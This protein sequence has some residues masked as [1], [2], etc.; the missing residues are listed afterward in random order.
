MEIT[1][2]PANISK[3][4]LRVEQLLQNTY[5]MLEEDLRLPKR[6]ET[7]HVPGYGKRKKKKQRQENRDKTCTSGREL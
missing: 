4:Q 1:F 2:L 7:P 6:Q 5:R 3:L